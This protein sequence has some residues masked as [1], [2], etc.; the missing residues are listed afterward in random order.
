MTFGV[1]AHRAEEP[2]DATLRRADAA[3]YEGKT[4]GRNQ[5]TPEAA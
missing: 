1:S 4:H 3:L 2:L 5:V